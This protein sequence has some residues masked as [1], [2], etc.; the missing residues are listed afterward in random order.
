V[1]WF[2]G[3]NGIY[4]R[5]D[6]KTGA[7]ALFDAPRGTG[8]YG[9]ATTPDGQVFFAS[10]AGNYLG[11][12]DPEADRVTVLEPPV[13]RQGARCVWSDSRGSYAGDWVTRLIRRRGEPA[14]L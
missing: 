12:I 10:L 5:L 3:Q 8:P 7:L 9:I 14:I 2:T 4:G 13:A 11:Q 1:L 6:V